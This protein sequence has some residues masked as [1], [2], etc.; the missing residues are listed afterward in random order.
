M[1]INS[2]CNSAHCLENFRARQNSEIF[3]CHSPARWAQPQLRS[4]WFPGL[5]GPGNFQPQT[6][7][8]WGI[9]F[10][11]G[12]GRGTARRE[13]LLGAGGEKQRGKLQ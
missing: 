9:C 3:F 1:F 12:Q 7:P 6:H 2:L 5:Q 11:V 10:C 4:S 13:A 8:G